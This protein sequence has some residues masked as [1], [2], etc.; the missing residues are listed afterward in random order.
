MSR[1]LAMLLGSVMGVGLAAPASACSIWC[2]LS[3][4]PG[5]RSMLEILMVLP[6]AAIVIFAFVQALRYTLRPGERAP[7]HIKW[8][9]LEEDQDNL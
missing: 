2:A 4:A 1:A 5:P 9:I 3:V 8:R 6:V 7:E